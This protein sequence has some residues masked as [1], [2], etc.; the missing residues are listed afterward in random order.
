MSE[1]VSEVGSVLLS[2]TLCR[3]KTRICNRLG[4]RN[5]PILIVECLSRVK[6]DS[7]IVVSLLVTRVRPSHLKCRGFGLSQAWAILRPFHLKCRNGT[8]LGRFEKSRQAAIAF[9]VART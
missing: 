8:V 3:D 5:C 9:C 6:W 4:G 2:G 1:V 7:F